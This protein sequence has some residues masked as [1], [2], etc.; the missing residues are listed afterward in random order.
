MKFT[1]TPLKGAYVVDLE[2]KGDH[3]G[4]FAR[5]YCSKEFAELGLESQFVQA[6]SSF[7]IHKGTIRGLHYQMSPMDEVKLVRCIAGSLYDVI[8]DLRSD[9]QTFGQYFGTTLSAENKR[10]VYVPKGF[11][12]GFLTLEDN[13]EILYLVSQYY[14][15]DLERGIR[16]NDPLFGIEWPAT[17]TVIS[18]RDM[19]HPDF[20][21]RHHMGILYAEP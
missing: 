4:F 13:T 17:P 7:S 20:D 10:M 12:H 2:K 16:W 9:S 3:R 14:S 11:A 5:M 15:S 6:N 19:T 21:R 18:E 1:E 8:L